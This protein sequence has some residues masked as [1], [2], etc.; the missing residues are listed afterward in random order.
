VGFKTEKEV[1]IA[2]EHFNNTF[3]QAS[4]IKVELCASLGK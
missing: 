4:K 1:Q 2:V 3:I